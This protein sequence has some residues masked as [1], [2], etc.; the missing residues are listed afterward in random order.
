MRVVH[1]V[2]LDTNTC[3]YVC[4]CVSFCYI[5]AKPLGRVPY[6]F[7][8]LCLGSCSV[9]I[10]G[11]SCSFSSI[12]LHRKDIYIMSSL[13]Q[14]QGKLQWITYYIPVLHINTHT[15]NEP[16]SRSGSPCQWTRVSRSLGYVCTSVCM[17]DVYSM[18]VFFFI[19]INTMGWDLPV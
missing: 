5:T 16:L 1:E 8:L 12:V 7:Q 4:L 2:L 17:C 15:H 19:I 3:T 13:L 6:F 10:L 9:L 18:L 14:V 11:R